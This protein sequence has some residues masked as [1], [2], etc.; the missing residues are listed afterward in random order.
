M[1]LGDMNL[2]AVDL[3]TF[4]RTSLFHDVCSSES[5]LEGYLR[6]VI[7]AILSSLNW[8]L[9]SSAFP[10]LSS[11]GCT[12]QWIVCHTGFSSRNN[13]QDE[14]TMTTH[15]LL[16]NWQW[17]SHLHL[18]LCLQSSKLHTPSCVQNQYVSVFNYHSWAICIIIV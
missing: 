11:F 2:L 12:L 18:S 3:F 13:L 6:S 4:F 5:K 16:N 7:M 1:V 8:R 10:S 9:T 14:A 15:I 17:F